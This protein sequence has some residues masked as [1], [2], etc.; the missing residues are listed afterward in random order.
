MIIIT[1][2]TENIFKSDLD[3]FR[4][5]SP[6][7][8]CYY[9]AFSE[10]PIDRA[11]LCTEFL[12]AVQ[13]TTWFY[14]ARAYVFFD[15]DIFLLLEGVEEREFRL[16]L[17]MLSEALQEQEILSHSYTLHVSNQWEK[18]MMLSS[19]GIDTDNPELEENISRIQASD[20]PAIPELLA[21]QNP[22]LVYSL[23]ERR[24][25][26]SKSTILIADDDLLART[27]VANILEKQYNIEFASSGL[28]ALSEYIKCAPDILLLD[29]G[30]PDIDGYRVLDTLLGVDREAYV[31]M[32]SGRNDPQSIMKAIDL[33]ARGFL[34]K[35][36]T[37]KKLLYH[38]DNR[39]RMKERAAL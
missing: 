10:V 32:F 26:R 16:F 11:D 31:I 33:G 39:N 1:K 27:M 38:L 4:E 20:T 23:S 6:E 24:N 34:A 35:P 37:R 17:K 19:K 18:I 14:E 5:R 9:I 36:F 8:R 3:S 25:E 2:D 7:G 29:I 13:S 22:D 21:G 15:K 30:M 12:K 28:E